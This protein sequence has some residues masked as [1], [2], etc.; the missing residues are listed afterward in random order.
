MYYIV[1]YETWENYGQPFSEFNLAFMIQ[2]LKMP[3]AKIEFVD[4]NTV[5]VVWHPN[6]ERTYEDLYSGKSFETFQRSE[7][8]A[9]W[10]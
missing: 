6:W 4:K 9:Y 5:Q 1:D 10:Q 7:N 3:N 8:N 2:Q